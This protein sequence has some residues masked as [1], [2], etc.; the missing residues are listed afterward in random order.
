VLAV[1]GTDT[2]DAAAIAEKLRAQVAGTAVEADGKTIAVTISLGVA[3]WDP[4][5]PAETAIAQA[6]AA[7]YRAKEEGRNRCEV[8]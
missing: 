8:A 4:D 1:P 5:A 2:G 6:D 3:A 7:L